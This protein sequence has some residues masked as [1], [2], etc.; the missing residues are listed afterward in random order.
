MPRRTR[1]AATLSIA[2]LTCVAALATRPAGATD[3][4]PV[5]AAAAAT[6]VAP[7]APVE[8]DVAGLARGAAAVASEEPPLCRAT[9]GA[10]LDG[11]LAK[12]PRLG[13]CRCGCGA[14]C[15]TDADCGPGG[16]CVGF[17]SCC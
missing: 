6:A 1:L 10:A 16:S 4:A 12:P 14:R 13:Y 7:C 3:L 9:D 17:I 2:A 8:V 11:V 15:Q 5:P